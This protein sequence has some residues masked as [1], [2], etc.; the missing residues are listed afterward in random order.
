MKIN[1]KMLLYFTVN[2]KM[3][4]NGKHAGGFYEKTDKDHGRRQI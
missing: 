3:Y 1:K 4:S 2:V